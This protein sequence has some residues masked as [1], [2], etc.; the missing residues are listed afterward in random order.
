MSKPQMVT[1]VERTAAADSAPTETPRSLLDLM[2]DGFYM[3]LLVKRGQMPTEE[4]PFADA[5]RQFLASMERTAVRLGVPSEDIYASKYAYCAAV[6]E[7]ILSSPGCT[8]RDSWERNPL[9]LSLF[10]DHLAGENFFTRLEQLR[11]Q[12]APRLQSLEV[13]Y[14][15]LLLGFEGK[16][17]LEG[18]EKL[19]YLTARLGDEIVYLKGHR[20]GFAPH[21]A[22]P[23]RVTHALRRSVPLWAPTAVLGVVGI[24]GYVLLRTMLGGEVT[25]RLADYHDL[26]QMPARTAS[27][28]IT[29]P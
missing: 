27:L 5:V 4:Q 17:R 26:V 19:G 9:Q 18:T 28:T 23:D 29:L 22:P 6:D 2:S 7:A 21:W 8:F 14:F 20:A 1:H 13:C 11:A 12:G 25:H 10:G 24:G 16:Y 15:C 3:L